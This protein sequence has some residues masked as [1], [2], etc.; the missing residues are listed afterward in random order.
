MEQNVPTL[1]PF[2]ARALTGVCVVAMV[3][4]LAKVGASDCT[5]RQTTIHVILIVSSQLLGSFWSGV[6]S[7]QECSGMVSLN[8]AVFLYFLL[9][10]ECTLQCFFCLFFG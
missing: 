2:V 3:P 6:G 7:Q 9:H 10:S 4:N 5:P 8:T 1:M